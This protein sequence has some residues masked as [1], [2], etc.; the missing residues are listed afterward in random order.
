M[1]KKLIQ[2]S[3]S[4]TLRY[5]Q[6]AGWRCEVKELEPIDACMLVGELNTKVFEYK[7]SWV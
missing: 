6:K 5:S 4:T 7:G 3:C 1:A 2:D